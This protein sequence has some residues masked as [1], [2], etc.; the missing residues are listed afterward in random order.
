MHWAEAGLCDDVGQACIG[1]FSVS[2]VQVSLCD[3]N[4]VS[5]LHRQ[6]ANGTGN[7][8]RQLVLHGEHVDHHRLEPGQPL[9]EGGF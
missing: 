5:L 1:M 3:M 4:H 8:C 9:G 7:F 2:E 6:R